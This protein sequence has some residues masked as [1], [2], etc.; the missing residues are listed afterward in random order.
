MTIELAT[1][2]A[3]TI[4]PVRAQPGAKR[5]AIVGEQAGALKVAV[6]EKPEGGKATAAIAEALADSLRIAKSRV[7]LL[8]GASSRQK[9]FVLRDVSLETA[10]T[11][12]DGVLKRDE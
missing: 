5:T 6:T 3:G 10:Q 2:A 4:L 11:W 1:H 12:L 7:E 8:S 9:R